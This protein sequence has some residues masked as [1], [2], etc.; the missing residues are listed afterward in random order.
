MGIKIIATSVESFTKIENKLKELK[1]DFTRKFDTA[2][3]YLGGF[4]DIQLYA[5]HFIDDKIELS[6]GS[7]I[8]E[9]EN[10]S[11]NE[12]EKTQKTGDIK[13]IKRYRIKIKMLLNEQ[14]YILIYDNMRSMEIKI[15]IMRY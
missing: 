6:K 8:T 2:E 12:F 9:V 4:S 3:L 7:I 14:S 1:E 15:S 13:E 10:E 5:Q 11:F